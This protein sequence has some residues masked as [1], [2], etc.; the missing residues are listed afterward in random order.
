MDFTVLKGSFNVCQRGLWHPD[1]LAALS[2]Y[3]AAMSAPTSPFLPP[4][5]AWCWCA[6]LL[7]SVASCRSSVPQYPLAQLLPPDY[8][9][10]LARTNALNLAASPLCQGLGTQWDSVLVVKPYMPEATVAA[11]PLA[12]YAAVS[13]LVTRQS[14]WD[15]NCT[16]L[17][18]RAGRYVAASVVPRTLDWV[19]LTKQPATEVVWLTPHDRAHLQLRRVPTFAPTDSSS[20]YVV[21]RVEN[22]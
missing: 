21:V 8:V 10:L 16:L 20:R 13:S 22:P 1:C 4:R 3:L 5:S 9:A 14:G 17:F 6:G 11:L 19:P 2:R 12:N 7:L 18:V 15:Q